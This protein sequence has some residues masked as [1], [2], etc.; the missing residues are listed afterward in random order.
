MA[1]MLSE[2]NRAKTE[3]R[4]VLSQLLGPTLPGVNAFG[5]S[6][7]RATGQRVVRV[8][9]DP[10]VPQRVR[11]QVPHS[12]GKVPVHVQESQAADFE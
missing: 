8:D 3:V 11:I 10:T 5:V 9:F 4:R 2:L 1:T 12:V 7:D 6:Y